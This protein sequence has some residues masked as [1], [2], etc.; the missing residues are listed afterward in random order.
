MKNCH[1]CGEDIPEDAKACQR[2]HSDLAVPPLSAA[3]LKQDTS[4]DANARRIVRYVLI[5]FSIMFLMAAFLIRDMLRPRG[6]Y[7]TPSVGT[8]RWI[9]D[10]EKTYAATHS[11]GFSRDIKSLE[12]TVN[13]DTADSDWGIEKALAAGVKSGYRFSYVASPPDQNGV[14]NSYTV[15]ADPIN[16]ADTGRNHYFTDQTGI[17]RQEQKR[18]ADENSSVLAG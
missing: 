15:Y 18:P 13:P 10:T 11:T 14:I 7:G 9:N 12:A 4:G 2:C 5:A 1:F 6:N 3:P 8:L 17:I 16:P